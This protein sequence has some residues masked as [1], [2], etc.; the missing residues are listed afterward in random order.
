LGVAVVLALGAAGCGDDD[1]EAN[2]GGASQTTTAGQT[3]D[4]PAEPEELFPLRFAVATPTVDPTSAHYA[5]VPLGAGYW[6]AEGLDVTVQ[7][8]PGSAAALASLE[9]GQI[10]AINV[11]MSAFLAARAAG[12]DAVA[13]YATTLSVSADVAV[14]TDSEIQSYADL[15]GAIIG[16]RELGSN[17]VGLLK[18]ALAAEGLDP[19]QDVQFIAVGTGAPSIEALRRGD[20]DAYLGADSEFAGFENADF[21]EFRLL[22]RNDAIE[23]V[24]GSGITVVTS[25]FFEENPD[26]VLALIRGHAMGGVFSRQ[27]P[28]AAV[29]VAYEL[30]PEVQPDLPEEEA[31]EQGVRL[32][33][34]RLRNALPDEGELLG[35]PDPERLE[36]YVEFLATELEDPSTMP[37]IEDWAR[38]DLV[39]EAND[40]DHEAVEADADAG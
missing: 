3:A 4:E 21:S 5:Q 39:E 23:I 9:A 17:N 29:R 31:V 24:E 15:D 12:V 32:L 10:D 38:F 40:F 13:V 26:Q 33:E 11:G 36:A 35:M 18:T 34:A 25:S 8:I 30:F 6:E 37:P 14:S 1:D 20:I 22:P 16:V 27:N 7:A 19:E 2:A 28:A